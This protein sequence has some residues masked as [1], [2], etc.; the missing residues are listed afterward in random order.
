M[1]LLSAMLAVTLETISPKIDEEEELGLRLQARK[2]LFASVFRTVAKKATALGQRVKFLFHLVRPYRAQFERVRCWS[3][4]GTHLEVE[5]HLLS[6][7]DGFK[8]FAKVN[9]LA[10]VQHFRLCRKVKVVR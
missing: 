4:S 6:T 1:L 2:S 5:S 7:I 3:W 9:D 8:V 10:D